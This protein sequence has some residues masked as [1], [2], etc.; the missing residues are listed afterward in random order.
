MLKLLLLLLLCKIIKLNYAYFTSDFNSWL[1]E[2]Y[3]PP[4]QSLLNRADLGRL[5]S[6]GGKQY[7]QQVLRREPV[8]FVHGMTGMAGE[9]PLSAAAHFLAS[10]YDWSELYATTYGSG[11]EGDPFQWTKQS[12][13]CQ[14]VKQI[15]MLIIAVR[16]Y[17]GR[18]VDVIAE[19][20]GV[21]LAR[22][23]IHGGQCVDTG[24]DLGG[25]LAASIDTFVGVAGP[26]HGIIFRVENI[27]FPICMFKMLP[28]C[29]PVTGVSSTMCPTLSQFLMVENIGFPICMF[30][31]LPIC[32][33]VTGVSSTMCPTL[34]QFLMITGQIPGQ[35]GEKV[36]GIA[37]HRAIFIR[38][39]EVQRLMVLR[40]IVSR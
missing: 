36:Y 16:L 32:D 33:P 37:T 8:I 14:F 26:N 15:R 23:A 27:G 38:S 4:I 5:G 3:G 35:Q 21:L 31:M 28:I 34:S 19:S 25:T 12:L 9:Q 1:M 39:L 6:F 29:D 11:T 20:M 10:G 40:H 24:E 22:K 18:A 7:R 2:V 30:K 17:T 13:T